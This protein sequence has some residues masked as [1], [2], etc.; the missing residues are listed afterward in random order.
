MID[1][2]IAADD[3]SAVQRIEGL[4]W[5][6]ADLVVDRGRA[7]VRTRQDLL[8][9]RKQRRAEH[10]RQQHDRAAMRYRLIPQAFMTVSS[11]VRDS[12]PKV[13]STLSSAAIGMTKYTNCGVL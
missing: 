3:P 11:L 8:V 10:Q 9:E 6:A 4:R 12:S 7:A 1:G 13:T 5:T 2:P